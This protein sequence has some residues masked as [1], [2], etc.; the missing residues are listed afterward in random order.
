MRPV[1]VYAKRQ[2]QG[3]VRLVISDNPN[4]VLNAGRDPIYQIDSVWVDLGG[5]VNQ[6]FVK[7]GP[8]KKGQV[9]EGNHTKTESSKKRSSDDASSTR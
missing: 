5:V 7:E 9:S 8:G 4:A 6:I 2:P 3:D 1:V